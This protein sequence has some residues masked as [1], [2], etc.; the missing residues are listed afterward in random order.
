MFNNETVYTLLYIILASNLHLAFSICCNGLHEKFVTLSG[1][2]FFYQEI[3]FNGSF[4]DILRVT[5]I[6]CVLMGDFS[7][8]IWK[9]Q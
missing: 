1:K 4:F 7:G 8:K 6:T 2:E 3:W 5:E 9:L